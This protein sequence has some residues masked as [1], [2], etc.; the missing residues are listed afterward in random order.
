MV[1]ILASHPATWASEAVAQRP[2]LSSK[3]SMAVLGT[4]NKKA[5]QYLIENKGADINEDVLHEII[6]LSLIHI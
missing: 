1:E 5:G 3:V 2:K 6:S 4:N